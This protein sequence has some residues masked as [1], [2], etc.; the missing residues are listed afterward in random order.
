MP[1]RCEKKRELNMRGHRGQFWAGGSSLPALHAVGS[2]ISFC[3]HGTIQFLAVW[4]ATGSF[5]GIAIL[6]RELVMPPVTTSN[7]MATG[8]QSQSTITKYHVAMSERRMK[9]TYKRSL[10]NDR[11]YRSRRPCTQGNTVFNN[12]VNDGNKHQYICSYTP[13]PDKPGDKI[14]S[15]SEPD[16][17]R[18]FNRANREQI[19]FRLRLRGPRGSG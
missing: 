3:N 14:G 18:N 13:A 10:R 6:V 15:D 7:S 11:P 9:H 8:S 5:P 17:K 1:E 16:S 4:F 12:Q 2:I 19:K